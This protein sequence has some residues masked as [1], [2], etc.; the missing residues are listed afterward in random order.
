MLA[1]GVDIRLLHLGRL[2]RCNVPFSM[3]STQQC[4]LLLSLLGDVQVWVGPWSTLHQGCGMVLMLSFVHPKVGFGEVPSYQGICPF[5][6]LGDPQ[7]FLA[8]EYTIF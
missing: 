6:F 4:C 8:P 5:F 7:D 3:R 2:Q 1:H